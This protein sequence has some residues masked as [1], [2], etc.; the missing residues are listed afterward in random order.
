MNK[1]SLKASDEK[2][3][4]S[5][6]FLTVWISVLDISGPYFPFGCISP[7]TMENASIG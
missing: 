6:A 5:R 3:L 7:L 1:G 4:L 2:T